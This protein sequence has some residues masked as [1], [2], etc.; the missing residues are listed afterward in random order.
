MQQADFI[1]GL[2]KG[3]G[4]LQAFDV[5]RQRLNATQAAQRVGLTRAAARR[6]LLTLQALGYLDS[7][8]T[9]FWLTAKVLQFSG[10]YLASAQLPR[11]AQPTLDALG[12]HTDGAFSV[13]VADGAEV[14][15]VARGRDSLRAAVAQLPP[16]GSSADNRLQE[17]QASIAHARS[18]MGMAQGLHLGAR[19]PMHATS[20]GQVLMAHWSSAQLEAWLQQHALRPLTPYTITTV[21]ALKK[22]LQRIRKCGWCCASQ[23]HELGVQGLAVPVYRGDGH[24]VGALNVVN[25][26]ALGKPTAASDEDAVAQQWL[27]WLQEA[28]QRMR[29]LL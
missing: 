26:V 11:V 2:G 9:Q 17:R 8:G 5:N 23:E 7:D 24:V 19:L 4:V 22:R 6:Y 13:V 27:A 29:T 14:V 1:A 21:T 10:N 12:M 28:A 25:S 18:V 16:S 3:L 20:T 15:I